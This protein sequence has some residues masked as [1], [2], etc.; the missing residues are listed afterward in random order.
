MRVDE[1]SSRRALIPAELQGRAGEGLAFSRRPR[2]G[3]R[4]PRGLRFGGRE[5]ATENPHPVPV[6]CPIGTRS[7]RR[8]QNTRPYTRPFPRVCAWAPLR[9]RRRA[10]GR[11]DP[12]AE[13][14]TSGSGAFTRWWRRDIHVRRLLS[15]A[16]RRIPRAQRRSTE[17]CVVVGHEE[18]VARPSSNAHL[19]HSPIRRGSSPVSTVAARQFAERPG[20]LRCGCAAF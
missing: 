6:P 4:D 13:S 3:K 1:A 2:K 20:M 10:G 5:M 8:A 15:I 12:D 7:I 16:E 14:Q 9:L 17:G 19:S 11:G 18:K